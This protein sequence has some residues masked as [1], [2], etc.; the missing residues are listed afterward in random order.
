[1]PCASTASMSRGRQPASASA[2]ANHL[3]L[4]RT[5]GRRQALAAAVLIDRRCR[6]SRPAPDGPLR[7]ASARRSSTSTPQPSAQPAPSAASANALHRPSAARPRSR[8]NSTKAAGVSI[9]VTPPASASVALPRA[10][11]LARQVDRDQRRRARRVDGQRRPLQAQRVGDAARGDARRA[12]RADV[13][14]E[15]RRRAQTR[16]P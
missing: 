5:V 16:L 12:A 7:C 4:R 1:M 10:Q 9:T 14:I 15:L 8:L 2:C 6:G 11:R 13:A 3:L